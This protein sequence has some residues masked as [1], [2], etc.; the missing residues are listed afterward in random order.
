MPA[1]PPQLSCAVESVARARVETAVHAEFSCS[2]AWVVP[3]GPPAP[4][5]S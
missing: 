3:W 5:P 2:Y 1:G 4:L